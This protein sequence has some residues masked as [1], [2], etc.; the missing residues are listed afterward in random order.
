MKTCIFQICI[1]AVN[2]FFFDRLPSF[3][4]FY[5]QL[6]GSYNFLASSKDVRLYVPGG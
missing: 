1:C 4:H 6:K 2:S 5:Q 3:T